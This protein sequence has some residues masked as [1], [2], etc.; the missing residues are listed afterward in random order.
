MKKKVGNYLLEKIKEIDDLNLYLATEKT[1][2]KKYIAKEFVRKDVEN[3]PE[4]KY[5]KN[6]ATILKD[7][8][9]PNIIKLEELKKT[10]NDYYFLMEYVNGGDLYDALVAYKE[11]NGKPFSEEIVQYLM[12]QIVDALK[13]IH[14][15]N[16]IH[17]NI[18]LDN[19]L[20]NF[21]TEEDKKNL[22]MLKSQ[23]KI[24]NFFFSSY[25]EKTGILKSVVGT[26]LNMDPIILK[27][28]NSGEKNDNL[29]YDKKADIWSLGTIFYEML[30]GKNPFESEDMEELCQKIEDGSYS[31][32]TTISND[33]ISFLT[34]MLKYESHKRLNIEKL[35]EHPFL[36][37]SVKD[38]DKNIYY[39]SSE[40]E[41]KLNTKE[42]TTNVD[43]EEMVDLSLEEL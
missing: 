35:S 2:N 40:K 7:L 25:V 22:N 21:E 14:G 24:S 34:G 43:E 20:L 10:K 17:R 36:N 28:L 9:H 13:Y 30:I 37:K 16:I 1:T 41:V 27:K 18:K 39:N 38:F 19:I 31:L 8:N 11:K 6:E 23:I 33:A 42:E 26:P 4:M 15:K 12:I 5:I 29:G 3:T 32:P